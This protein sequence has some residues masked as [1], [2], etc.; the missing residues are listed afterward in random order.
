[1]MMTK[2][3]RMTKISRRGMDGWMDGWKGFATH[4]HTGCL[5]FGQVNVSVSDKVFDRNHVP[6]VSDKRRETFSNSLILR[7]ILDR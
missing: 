5:K 7:R 4:M 1:M 3:R 6:R 2:R